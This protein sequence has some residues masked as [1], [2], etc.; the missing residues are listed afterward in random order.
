MSKKNS[1]KI[2]PDPIEL[3]DEIS[4]QISQEG[5]QETRQSHGH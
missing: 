3:K 2:L 5:G 4:C 1:N